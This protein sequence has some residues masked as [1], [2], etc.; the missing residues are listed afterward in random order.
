[1]KDKIIDVEKLM[2]DENIPMST[3]VEIVTELA[4]AERAL[5]IAEGFS[6]LFK[7]IGNLF[8]SEEKLKEEKGLA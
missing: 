8:K 3:K 2:E 1:M 4:R 5:V 7:A 6:K